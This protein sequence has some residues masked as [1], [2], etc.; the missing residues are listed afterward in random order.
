MAY[1]WLGFHRSANGSGKQTWLTFCNPELWIKREDLLTW[2]TNICERN[3]GLQWLLERKERGRQNRNTHCNE[4]IS[5]ICK[6]CRLRS[7]KWLFNK[8][9]LEAERIYLL[10]FSLC[11][12]DHTEGR[13]HEYFSMNMVNWIMYVFVFV[14]ITMK[15]AVDYYHFMTT[16]VT[17]L[18]K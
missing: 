7:I 6:R 16:F 12:L 1:T 17:E 15:N 11:S 5:Q 9:W 10:R 14:W 2:Q 3:I 8:S 4:T 18:W 13:R